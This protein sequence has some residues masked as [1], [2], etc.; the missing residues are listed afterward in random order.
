MNSYKHAQ[1]ARRSVRVASTSARIEVSIIDDGA[2]FDPDA[3]RKEH[4]LG[5]TG[6]KERVEV[7]GGTFR[8][9][10]GSDAGTTVTVDLPD[11]IE[12]HDD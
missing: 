1:G 2:G 3:V 10:S 8:V 12:E 6:M 11:R 4:S 5:L 7:L 9:T